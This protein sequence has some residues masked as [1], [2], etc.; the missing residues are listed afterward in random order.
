MEI[1]PRTNDCDPERVAVVFYKLAGFYTIIE[2]SGDN[3][4]A[5]LERE[6]VEAVYR[7]PSMDRRDIKIRAKMEEVM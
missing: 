5:I 7:E 1:T 3:H 2:V 4:D 6:W